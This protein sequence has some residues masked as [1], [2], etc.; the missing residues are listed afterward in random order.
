MYI[1]NIAWA[2]LIVNNFSDL[3][4][5]TRKQS[6]PPPSALFCSHP[7]LML[8]LKI[9]SPYYSQRFC[10]SLPG[11]GAVPARWQWPL[12]AS[13]KIPQLLLPT[14]QKQLY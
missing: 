14:H 13:P 9:E 2:I 11:R 3:L 1:L 12:Q 6:F 8:P 7:V 5:H 4:A 10:L